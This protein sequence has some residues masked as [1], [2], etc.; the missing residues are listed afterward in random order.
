MN[1][2]G[3]GPGFGQAWSNTVNLI[4]LK[5]SPPSVPGGPVTLIGSP[6]YTGNV[7]TPPLFAN[8]TQIHWGSG[9]TANDS[10]TTALPSVFLSDATGSGGTNV[11]ALQL[12]RTGAVG[13]AYT[14]T[15]AIMPLFPI[16]STPECGIY[17]SDGTKVITQANGSISGQ[18][19]EEVKKYATVSSAPSNLVSTNSTFGLNGFIW[20]QI[21]SDTV[22]RTYSVSTD[23][24]NFLPRET[25]TVAGS[26]LINTESVV[27]FYV[28]L[29]GSTSSAVSLVSWRMTS[30]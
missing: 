30:P 25:E 17:V 23:G 9:T 10:G 21:K 15:A 2:G 26:T 29:N 24:I 4:G 11:R 1:N 5:A 7:T 19:I 14:L 16:A 28:S 27:G 13:T 12:P 3:A 20:M 8:W 18:N 6:G 22:N